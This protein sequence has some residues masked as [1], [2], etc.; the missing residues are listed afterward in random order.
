LSSDADAAYFDDDQ[1]FT[2]FIL[3]DNQTVSLNSYYPD[4]DHHVENVIIPDTVE[5]DGVVYTVID[6]F[7]IFYFDWIKTIT[8]PEHIQ[9]ISL[10]AFTGENIESIIVDPENTYFESMDG[11]LYNESMRSLL[12]Y[13]CGKTDLSFEVPN[14]VGILERRCFSGCLLEEITLPVQLF[15]INSSAFAGCLNLSKINNTD[16]YNTL[17]D[18]I[19]IIDDDAFCDCTSLDNIILPKNLRILG[20]C[21]LQG[22][23][24]KTVEIPYSVSMVGFMA[25][26]YC[27]ELESITTDFNPIYKSEDGVL[28]KDDGFIS[29]ITYPAGKKDT[30]FSINTSTND[31]WPGAFAGCEYLTKITLPNTM[32]MAPREAFL[33][34]YS[35]SEINLDS[36]LIIG[37]SAFEGCLNLHNITLGEDLASIGMLAFASTGLESVDIP[38]SVITISMEAFLD[39]TNLEIVNFREGCQTEIESDVFYQDNELYMISIYSEKLKFEDGAFDVGTIDEPAEIMV[40]KPKGYTLPENVVTDEYT[41]LDIHDRGERPYPYE[42]FLGIFLCI[43]VVIG[44]FK[45]FRGV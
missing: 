39:C 32:V 1:G 4:G 33:D 20:S 41:I 36:L 5:H 3:E 14:S 29:L 23:A 43:L 28:Y 31:I 9:S 16:G 25:F 45:L 40:I 10:P 13:P 18:D 35:L 8:I 11:I 22:T 2:Y 6:I 17:P 26:S 38:D 24:L 12:T 34:C 21:A 15:A 7:A 27:K 44:I 19:A 42:N 30:E 37:D